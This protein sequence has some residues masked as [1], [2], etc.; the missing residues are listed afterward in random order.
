MTKI[1]GM[2]L[3]SYLNFTPINYDNTVVLDFKGKFD[4]K[5]TDNEI[6]QNNKYY[7]HYLINVDD[8]EQDVPFGTLITL[9]E[10]AHIIKIINSEIKENRDI[11]VHCN[12][13]VSRTGAVI[14]VCYKLLRLTSYK[15]LIKSNGLINSS[16]ITDNNF[17]LEYAPNKLIISKL[18]STL[19][20]GS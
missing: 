2:D 19:E 20:T 3:T 14:F 18:E 5:P 12:A 9:E 15:I 7:K 17:N 11:V 13:G 4:P 16:L 1:Y 8:I 10:S 6:F